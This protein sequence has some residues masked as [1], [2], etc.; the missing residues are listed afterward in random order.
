MGSHFH[1]RNAELVA[2]I[3]ER[4]TDVCP[5]EVFAM[6]CSYAFTA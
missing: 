6:L 5:W 3:L 4:E 2:Q 1:V